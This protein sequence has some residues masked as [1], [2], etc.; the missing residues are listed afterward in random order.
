MQVQEPETEPETATGR[1]KK[2]LVVVVLARMPA[3]KAL[4]QELASRCILRPMSRFLLSVLVLF[5]TLAAFG[6]AAPVVTE[7]QPSQGP[8]AGGTLVVIRGDNL[9]TPV[10]CILP[11][12]P[13]VTFG[14]VTVDAAEESDER[15]VVTTP[16][17]EAGTVDVTVSIPGREPVVV[18]NGFTFIAGHEAGYEQ[19]LLPIYLKSA[20]PGANGSLWRTDFYIRNN[21]T[22]AVQLAPWDCPP[23]M[24]CPPVFPL[25]HTLEPQRTLHNPENF[26]L[27]AGSNPSRLL[28]V[29]APANV[30]MS[31]RVADISRSVQNAGTDV[32]VIRPSEL[33]RGT[34]QL[35][36]V[37]LTDQNFRVLLRIYE[38]AYSRSGFVVRFHPQEGGLPPHEVTL[39][40][41]TPQ[42]GPF[43]SE[44][45]YVEFDVS[46]LL[47]LRRAWPDT[48]RIE[49]EPATPGSRYWAF[50]SITNNQTQFV[51]LVTPQ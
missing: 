1:G 46:A 35:F 4:P 31:L 9:S 37:P 30:S 43:R 50:A 6:Q 23:N 3:T 29:S 40:A 13:R 39:T 8:A 32:P 34:S 18:K 36:N 45:A 48:L 15:L 21:G 12:P 44:A 10:Q 28:Y 42:S 16:A 24:A 26:A 47:H 19:V 33:L 27:Y 38:V 20:A 51:T 22:T 7:I 5:T 49:I 14:D 25:T 2:A 17:H 11:C 41:A